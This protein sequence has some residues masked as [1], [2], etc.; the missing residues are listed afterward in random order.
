MAT[1]PSKKPASAAVNTR[2]GSEEAMT[3]VPFLWTVHHCWVS[4]R[5]LSVHSPVYSVGVERGIS[6]LPVCLTAIALGGMFSPRVIRMS[7]A[8]GA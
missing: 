7:E 2:V 3:I 8:T 4:S 1:S 6:E 5:T